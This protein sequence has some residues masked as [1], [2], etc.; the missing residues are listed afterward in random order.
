MQFTSICS[1]EQNR[2]LAALGCSFALATWLLAASG[3]VQ[4]S[5]FFEACVTDAA[6]LQSALTQASDGGIHNDED[7]VIEVV[8]GIYETGAATSNGP[9]LY[10]SSS[11]HYLFIEGGYVGSC[12]SPT[13]TFNPTISILDGNQAS[14][15][16]E[17]HTQY[18]ASVTSLTIQNGNSA[19]AGAGL[20]INTRPGDNGSVYVESNIIQN[21]HDTGTDGGL[22]AGGG[23]TGFIYVQDNLIVGNSADNGDG[24]GTVAGTGTGADVINNTVYGNTTAASGQFGGLYYT[25]EGNGFIANNIFYNN[26]NFGLYLGT[27]SVTVDYNDYG[28]LGGATPDLS[29]T[30]NVSVDPKFVDSSHGNFH[31]SSSSPLLGISPITDAQF[32]IDFLTYPTTGKVDLGAYEDTIFTDGFNGG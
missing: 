21:N 17:I 5:G 29:S 12:P 24:A 4:A 27:T 18:E 22:Y 32:D 30:G 26:T 3:K 28:A 9:F 10:S 14:A 2:T 8:Q 11:P 7:T 31:L 23:T 13:D 15:V 1:R 16:L 25:G 19:N 20:S 6:E